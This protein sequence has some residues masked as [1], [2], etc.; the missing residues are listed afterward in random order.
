MYL[1]QK[2]PQYSFS[3]GVKDPHTGDVKNQWE[4]RHGDQVEGRY[5][6]V[7]P[8][9]SVR[10]VSYS[11]DDKSG[12]NAVVKHSGVHYHPEGHPSSHS[13]VFIHTSASDNHEYTAA[14]HSP[15]KAL[16]PVNQHKINLGHDTKVEYQYELPKDEQ[17]E[18]KTSHESYSYEQSEDSSKVLS[19][20]YAPQQ[21]YFYLDHKK[22]APESFG[23]EK[24]KDS[25]TLSQHEIPIHTKHKPE[26]HLPVDLS[27]VLKSKEHPINQK[28]HKPIPLEVTVLKPIEIDL[29]LSQLKN[30]NLHQN[31][32]KR[33]HNNNVHSFHIPDIDLSLLKTHGHVKYSQPNKF[34]EPSHPF[35]KE[36]L[37][38][39]KHLYDEQVSY[40]TEHLH[41]NHF[42][43]PVIE[44]GFK[45]LTKQSQKIPPQS[46]S[47]RRP[48]LIKTGKKPHTTPGLRN[49]STSR[50]YLKYIFPPAVESKGKA[51]PPSYRNPKGPI[52]FP[53]N[54]DDRRGDVQNLHKR[55]INN[56]QLTYAQQVRYNQ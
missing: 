24:H 44:G 30:Y 27:E 2:Y 23:L 12:F 9:G 42:S 50:G 40:N 34:V 43:E 14:G 3:Y 51:R 41:E 33:P 28:E 26:H 55:M 20:Y 52:L 46:Q 37:D 16:G 32:H 29:D 31:N 35:T 21:S 56:G 1:F 36:E 4:K 11:A 49:F 18:L 25:V 54:S 15:I 48:G 45:P 39:Y 13:E 17:N 8:D 5:S 7:E 6:L 10:T 19:N 47:H 53:A 38:A 22:H